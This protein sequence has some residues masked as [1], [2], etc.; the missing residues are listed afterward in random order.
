MSALLA[1]AL[2]AATPEKPYLPTKKGTVLVYQFSSKPVQKPVQKPVK[3]A[4]QGEP[5]AA[6]PMPMPQEPSEYKITTT[7][8]EVKKTDAG[9][10][11]TIL[12]ETEGNEVSGTDTL[13]QN[14]KGLFT[15]G[16]SLIRPDPVEI[17]EKSWKFDPPACLIQLPHKNGS[18]WV[19]D[20][21][22]QPGGFYGLKAND[23]ANGPEELSVPAGK[24]MAIRVE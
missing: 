10:I 6:V 8:K 2:L 23:T 12:E 21:P 4:G 18:K 14:E 16:S 15:I 22:S 7:V 24:Y 20:C 13:L 3:K 19:F 5:K 17:K 9:V 11:V 1:L